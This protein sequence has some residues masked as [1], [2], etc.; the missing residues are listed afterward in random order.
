[1]AQTYKYI[2]VFLSAGESAQARLDTAIA[3]ARLHDARLTGLDVSTEAVF[4][5][6]LKRGMDSGGL[7]AFRRHLRGGAPLMRSDG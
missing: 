3:L 5:R 1:M 6:A 7:F 4:S 2:L